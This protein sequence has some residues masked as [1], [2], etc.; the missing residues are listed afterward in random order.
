MFHC[1]E[2]WVGTNLSLE[3]STSQPPELQMSMLQ[4]LSCSSAQWCCEHDF[5]FWWRRYYPIKTPSTYISF[6][7]DARSFH[8]RL[9][10]GDA[11][12]TATGDIPSSQ[13]EHMNQDT[14]TIKGTV[15]QEDSFVFL[16]KSSYYDG[17]DCL[18][19]FIFIYLGVQS[20]GLIFQLTVDKAT[21]EALGLQKIVLLALAE[22]VPIASMDPEDRKEF[23]IGVANSD[24]IMHSCFS[25]I[26][27]HD[28][29]NH[30]TWIVVQVYYQAASSMHS[31]SSNQG[32][33]CGLS[34]MPRKTTFG[35]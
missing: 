26:S 27:I 7:P 5:V 11:S 15:G 10:R 23:V 14:G 22:F 4:G 3:T 35:Q 20:Y 16:S 18:I 21:D 17:G 2:V 34:S 13:W 12:V 8:G 25:R 30:L 1:L 19:D 32:L 6:L 29:C 31:L 9:F 24:S 28:I 33:L